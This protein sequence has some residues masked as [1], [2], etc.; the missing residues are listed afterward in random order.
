MWVLGLLPAFVMIDSGT[1]IASPAWA[2]YGLP[3]AA[4]VLF[5]VWILYTGS[6]SSRFNPQGSVPQPPAGSSSPTSLKFVLVALMLGMFPAL[7]LHEIL[8]IAGE[9]L[10]GSSTVIGATVKV[11]ERHGAR[12]WC[13][14]TATFST[15][16]ATEVEIC[17]RHAVRDDLISADLLP[18][19]AVL[20]KIRQNWLGKFVDKVERRDRPSGGGR[21]EK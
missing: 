19:E 16:D 3:T 1:A 5:V 18:D 9:S 2:E 8:D 15:S 10:G 11:T 20:L 17:V 4:G 6:E 7:L 14:E 13:R 21:A 12:S